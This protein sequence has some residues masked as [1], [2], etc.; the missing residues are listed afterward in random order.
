MATHVTV[1]SLIALILREIIAY[2]MHAMNIALILFFVPSL[3]YRLVG[4]YSFVHN[5]T[6]QLLFKIWNIL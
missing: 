4:L 1:I 2:L 5:Y 6:L 3:A